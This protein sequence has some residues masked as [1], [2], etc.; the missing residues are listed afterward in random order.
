MLSITREE[1]SVIV[2]KGLCWISG[3]NFMNQVRGNKVLRISLSVKRQNAGNWSLDF[4]SAHPIGRAESI[5]GIG[6]C[7]CVCGYVRHFKDALLTAHR[8]HRG[9]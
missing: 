5:S 8:L 2:G 6:L 3:E 9:I 4:H 7:M 1:V